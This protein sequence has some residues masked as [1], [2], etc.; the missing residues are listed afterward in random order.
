MGQTDEGGVAD[1]RDA[2]R[3]KRDAERASHLEIVEKVLGAAEVRDLDADARD[4]ISTERDQAA[5]LKAFTSPDGD[6]GYGE[7][8]PA[9]RHAAQDRRDAKDDRTSAADDRAALTHV[10]DDPDEPDDA[11]ERARADDESP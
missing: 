6:N 11:P 9:R 2:T 3:A 7:N 8:L 1:P 4:L 5:D 10:A